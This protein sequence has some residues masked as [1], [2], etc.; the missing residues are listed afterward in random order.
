MPKGGCFMARLS[1]E[2]WRRQHAAE[3]AA[4]PV[5]GVNGRWQ[6]AV[7]HGAAHRAMGALGLGLLAL[8]LLLWPVSARA[9]NPF[10][11]APPRADLSQAPWRALGRVQTE[12]G[13]RCTGFLIGPDLVMTAAHCLY[14]PLTGHYVQP[15]S[16]HF[17]WR[18]A[19][20]AYAGEARA[21]RFVISPGFN[22]AEEDR[23][24]G[25][26]RAFL[27]L[28][29]PLGTRRDGLRFAP[30][31]PPLGSAVFLGGY[32][33]GHDEILQT[34]QCRLIKAGVDAGGHHLLLDDCPAEPGASGA[35]LLSLLPNGQW[36]VIGL[37][38][39]ASH[40]ESIAEPLTR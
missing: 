39:A 40:G 7:R 10:A 21:V 38:V 32:E 25:L 37:V 23:T 36:G 20:G 14:R 28:A 18:Y 6:A 13:T 5:R 11:P 24:M 35:P 29:H 1:F 30:R 3:V 22:P 19:R 4:A 33:R 31:L 9:S 27:I 26:D 8:G 34:E 17:L 16:V 12:L 2:C 15:G